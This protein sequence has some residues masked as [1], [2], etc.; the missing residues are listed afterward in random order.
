MCGSFKTRIFHH[1]VQ[2]AAFYFL[3]AMPAHTEILPGFRAVP[4]IVFF[5]VAHKIAAYLCSLLQELCCFHESKSICLR[6]KYN[7]FVINMQ[8][9]VPQKIIILVLE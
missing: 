2:S 7:I 4:H 6:C 3:R 1:A 8:G 9:L 5:A